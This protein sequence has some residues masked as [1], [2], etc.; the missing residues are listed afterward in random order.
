[1]LLGCSEAVGDILHE[2]ELG[3]HHPPASGALSVTLG[4]AGPDDD[5]VVLSAQGPARPY[6]TLAVSFDGAGAAT[7]VLSAGGGGEVLLQPDRVRVAADAPALVRVFGA[8][9]SDALGDVRVTARVEGGSQQAT[10][11]LTVIDGVSLAFAGNFQDRLATDPDQPTD[12]RGHNGSTRALEGEADLDDIIRFSA[13]VDLRLACTFTPV[14][15]TAVRA[16]RPAG[17]TF[18]AGDGLL[19]APIDLGPLS[20]FVDPDG[21]LS[22]E[23]IDG[24]ALQV[25]P[26]DARGPDPIGGP[27]GTRSGLELAPILAD[28]QGRQSLLEVER[29]RLDGGDLER[30]RIDARLALRTEF[31]YDTWQLRFTRSFCG[32]AAGTAG[33]GAAGS[34]LLPLFQAAGIDYRI[35]FFGFDADCL[36][37]RITGSLRPAGAAAPMLCPPPVTRPPTR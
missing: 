4:A 5:F 25:G 15:V 36:R 23:R 26:L 1:M 7:V 3:S 19:G 28:Y 37:G 18:T 9:A 30:R 29:A 16:E 2:I 12:P 21:D 13:P 17:A 34:Q 11:D 22:S 32:N 27:V 24:F 8:R 35:D 14:R 6:A 31:H 10:A 33:A 20:K